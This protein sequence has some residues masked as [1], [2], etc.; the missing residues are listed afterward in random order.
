[1][2]NFYN[3]T[4]HGKLWRNL[5][6]RLLTVI[7]VAL[8]LLF[9]GS[10]IGQTPFTAQQI[11]DG[12]TTNG[13]SVSNNGLST[14]SDRSICASTTV[15][16]PQLTSSADAN[17]STNYIQILSTETITS[18][19]LDIVAGTSYSG[20]A[21]YHA[22]IFFWKGNIDT[23]P[24]GVAL[25]PLTSN[26]GVCSDRIK[27]IAIPT[28]T[29]S[30]RI[31][32]RV[33]YDDAN[34]ILDGVAGSNYPSDPYNFTIAGMTV[35][36][37][38]SA[39]ITDQPEYATAC[40]G[41]AAQFSVTVAGSSP[42]YQWQYSPDDGTTPWVNINDGINGNFTYS[43]T[44]TASLS[45][46][47]AI[48]ATNG[49]YRCVT[50]VSCNSS[51]ETSGSALL[52][53]NNT[54]PTLGLINTS[55]VCEGT[56][57][58]INL[59]GLV[60]GVNTITYT[61]DGGATQNVDVTADAAGAGSFTIP[62][63]TNAQVVEITGITIGAGCTPQS[64]SGKTTTLSVKTSP[65]ITPAGNI[66]A[67][68]GDAA[69]NLTGNPAGGTWGSTNSV[70]ASVSGGTVTF[71]AVGSA[72]IT[73]TQNGCSKSVQ[74]TLNKAPGA[75]SEWQQ[76]FDSGFTAGSA[77]NNSTT[78]TN[79]TSGLTEGDWKYTGRSTSLKTTGTQSIY[80]YRTNGF[81]ES[82]S[83]TGKSV[84][85]KIA[86]KSTRGT[87]TDCGFR[88]LVNGSAINSLYIDGILAQAV[89]G[90]FLLDDAST[91]HTVVVPLR[92]VSTVRILGGNT[93]N[94]RAVYYLD[95]FA[96]S[97][98]YLEATPTTLTGF[99]Y[100]LGNGPSGIK[101]FITKGE[102]VV[103][104]LNIIK[105]TVSTTDAYEF[106]FDN[107]TTWASAGINWAIN[108]AQLTAG[109]EV[110]V[111]LKAGLILKDYPF[112]YQITATGYTGIAPVLSFAGRVGSLNI[113]CGTNPTQS[114]LSEVSL[115]NFISG[116][117]TTASCAS[118]SQSFT[119]NS[120]ATPSNGTFSFTS[121]ASS[122]MY[123]FSASATGTYGNTVSYLGAFPTTNGLTVYVR[124]KQGT[125]AG[126]VPEEIIT[127]NG[128][129]GI[130]VTRI[131]LSG[132][133]EAPK[134]NSP[135]DGETFNFVS[136]AGT[137]AV[138]YIDLN[139]TGVCQGMQVE[140]STCAGM[141]F[142]DCS[143]NS[144]SFANAN[145]NIQGNKLYLQ[146]TPTAGENA[147]TVKF[148]LADGS[149]QTI[150]VNWTGDNGT[151]TIVAA[152]GNLKIPQGE[153]GNMVITPVGFAAGDKIT[154]DA[155]PT[156]CTF[157]VAEPFTSVTQ[158]DA[159]KPFV[160]YIKP[161]GTNYGTIILKNGTTT[162]SFTISQ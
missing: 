119:I 158:F 91:F 17:I 28:G 16:A 108:T 152:K 61:V 153:T 57:A 39:S 134:L 157:S 46:T 59:T 147:C 41:V 72:T 71:G 7:L 9:G 48:G 12:N 101:S 123:E 24:D 21:K 40:T 56:S 135:A 43:G 140:S 112:D 83:I 133:V 151:K 154:I 37:C 88:V 58:T 103:G 137:Q 124:Q 127:I 5:R 26:G 148:T 115:T 161:S 129:A 146:Y 22:V 111:R 98:S 51:T 54:T 87:N 155:A 110:L 42:T 150:N 82:P 131:T 2:K 66:V 50:S 85:F 73:Y 159:D 30:I 19:I 1:M 144:G 49:H 138:R 114:W 79:T 104:T 35:T 84:S 62:N 100:A 63:P 162:T 4:V 10:L 53:I 102:N 78:T 94:D 69:I 141:N 145:T 20:V 86:A 44:S 65:T 125:T 99:T 92:G 3:A 126:A 132:K 106:S 13:I 107:G 105:T 15:S 90:G 55:Q 29:K 97:C 96:V 80:L 52:A 109:K 130:D 34:K 143:T 81:L 128:V 160:L 32:R 68:V 76:N 38:T 64:F 36:S 120:C 89:N 121:N 113:D 122:S 156:G 23:T 18:L 75:C 11:Y 6:N 116:I 136:T 149:T 70:T 45:V 77:D 142:S 8:E 117:G 74:V 139:T 67:T 27:T 60:T 25:V 93:S 118:A 47:P 14:L 33:K 31:Y 95:D